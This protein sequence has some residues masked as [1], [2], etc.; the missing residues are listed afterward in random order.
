MLIP[1][2]IKCS[3]QTVLNSKNTQYHILRSTSQMLSSHC[4][5]CLVQTVPISNYTLFK[6]LS[7]HTIKCSVQTVKNAQYTQ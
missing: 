6:I 4:T 7:T 3:V 1:Q 2:S 5:K